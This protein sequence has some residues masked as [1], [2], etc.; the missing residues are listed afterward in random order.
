LDK[1]QINSRN[2]EQKYGEVEGTLTEELCKKRVK[3]EVPEKKGS[4][5]RTPKSKPIDKKNFM[6]NI[7][8]EIEVECLLRK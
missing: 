2:E 6:N 4:H 7:Q 5:I 8:N 1:G 3:E